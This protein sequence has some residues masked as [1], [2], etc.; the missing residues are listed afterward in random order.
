MARANA[1]RAL[2]LPH[3]RELPQRLP[4]LFAAAGRRARMAGFDGIELHYAHA[5]TMASFLSATNDRRDGWRHQGKQNSTATGGVSRGPRGG[6]QRLRLD[7]VFSPKSAS[8]AERSLTPQRISVSSL[9][10]REW[11][12]CP[13]RAAASSTTPSSRMSARRSI[14]YTGYSG[15][16]CMPPI[17]SDGGGPFGRNAAATASVRGAIRA[18]GLATPVVCSGE[19]ITSKWPSEC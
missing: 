7:A 3:I 8:R 14:Q 18:A 10:G 15:F 2:D 1:S 4:A 19:C 11:I 12:S 9:L 17:Q 5:Y 6:G 16:E 13:L